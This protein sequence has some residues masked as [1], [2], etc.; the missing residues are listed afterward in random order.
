ML[1]TAKTQDD[2]TQGSIRF[3]F[4]LGTT[5]HTTHAMLKCKH[6]NRSTARARAIA[7]VRARARA[8]VSEG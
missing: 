2:R 7:R 1:E 4:T 5:R 3:H 6:T 8:E